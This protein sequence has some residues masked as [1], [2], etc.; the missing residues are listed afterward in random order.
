MSDVKTDETTARK[1]LRLWPGVVLVAI[2]WLAR[3]VVP[4]FAPD[5]FAFSVMAGVFGGAAALILW[6][7]FFSRAEWV[8]R[9]G[10]VVLMVIALFAAPFIL[11]ESIATASQGMLFIVYAIPPLFLAFV[12][13]AAAT[14]RL[15]NFVR[16][17][18]MAAAILLSCAAWAL[19][20]SDGTT[21]DFSNELAWRWTETSEERLLANADET[22]TAF[23]VTTDV[24]AQWPGFRGPN[25]N[26]V[27][28]GAQIQTDWTASP[29]VELWRR[30]VGP[31]W[32]SFT[33]RGDVFYTQEQRGEDEIVACYKMSDGELVWRHSDQ[34]RFWESIGGAGPRATPTYNNG[35]LFTL[36][37]T[38]I[39]N[40]LN[41]N[42]GSVIWKRDL[43]VDAEVKVPD[44]GFSSSP[45]VVDSLV[46]VAAVGKLVAYDLATGDPRWFS[47][48][49]GYGYSSPHL[50][51]IKSVPQILL[52]SGA[53]ALS[54][55]PFDGKLLWEHVWP[56]DSRI[57]QPILTPNGDLVIGSGFS[58]GI[59]TRRI[60][61]SQDLGGWAT[62]ER[63]TSNRLKP[64]FNDIVM[65]GGHAYGFDGSIMACID[66]ADGKRKW[67]GGRYGHGQL[68]L[69]PDQDLLLVISEKGNLALV[70]AA[71]EKFSEIAKFPAIKGKT[72][73]HPVLVDDTL[74]IR[75]AQEMAAFKLALANN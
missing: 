33:V 61:I 23:A 58:E 9:L 24:E 63:W 47:P 45:L 21:G 38:G 30:P 12:V 49:G 42:D 32:S 36:G 64:Y 27:V 71:P 56:A 59:G 44:W 51:I 22:P 4:V 3:F 20:R 34:A 39:F 68:V 6:W 53:G 2:M 19:A 28:P 35:R 41:A 5:A 65:H 52:L 48:K 7:V 17:V 57:V 1:P 66:L 60:A 43:A 13:W 55:A 54:V 74:L 72:W 18:T 73:N 70:E 16:R 29:P 8:E 11:H 10:A 37:A 40:A 25:R 69:L 67:K 26:G 15:S 46:I 75:N 31:G 50:M 14:R 62:E